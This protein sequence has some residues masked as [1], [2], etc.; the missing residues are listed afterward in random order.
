MPLIVLDV[1]V[2]PQ[3]LLGVLS[4]RLIEV[5]AGLFV[6]SVSKRAVETLW[7]L[8]S[9]SSAQSALLMYPARN[10][11][12]VGFRSCGESRHK[13]IDSDGLPLVAVFSKTANNVTKSSKKE[14]AC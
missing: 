4:R 14:D 1:C 6:G 12:G 3:A 5:R 7:T 8:V 9:E 13:I 11:L 2:A 10:E